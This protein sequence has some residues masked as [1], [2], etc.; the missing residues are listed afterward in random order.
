MAYGTAT[1]PVVATFPAVASFPSGFDTDALTYFATAG[2]TDP[3]TRGQINSFVVGLKNLGA[4]NSVVSWPLRSTQNAGTGTT[5]YSLGGLGSFPATLVESPTWGT[6]GISI[7]ATNTQCVNATIPITSTATII[8]VQRIDDQFG[9]VTRRTVGRYNFTT[10]QAVS[11]DNV[12]NALFVDMPESPSGRWS[13]PSSAFLAQGQ[14]MLY[15]VGANGTTRFFKRNDESISTATRTSSMSTGSLSFG[16]IGGG[17]GIGGCRNMTS[18]FTLY[19]QA[20]LSTI[21]SS[22]YSL[23][24]STIGQGLSLP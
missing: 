13:A 3:A 10:G 5:A 16:V 7:G 1:Y 11:A 6:S 17:S 18:A 24:K 8:T 4:W 22:I 23:Y 9:A 12:A 2:I 21:A 14:F 20:D 19:S 15:T